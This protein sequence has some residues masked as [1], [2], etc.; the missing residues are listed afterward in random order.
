M[1]TAVG[2]DDRNDKT[3]DTQH[4]RHDNGDDR[5]HHEVGLH[6]THRGHADARL[7]SAVRSPQVCER[8]VTHQFQQRVRRSASANGVERAADGGEARRA[9]PSGAHGRAAR[10]SCREPHKQ[11]CESAGRR[12]PLPE[13]WEGSLG[14]RSMRW[15]HALAKIR[16]TAAPMKPKNGAL[17]GHKSVIF[18]WSG[19][20]QREA[21]DSTRAAG[22]CCEGPPFATELDARW[23]LPPQ[24]APSFACCPDLPFAA[25]A[26]YKA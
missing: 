20:R 7:G 10:P 3:V 15:Q 24:C 6:H 11:S 2:N 16:A 25:R 13:E 23:G 1:R 8:G 5:L 22:D 14:R 9:R 4:T 12:H 17:A 21:C 19:L 26:G 18:A